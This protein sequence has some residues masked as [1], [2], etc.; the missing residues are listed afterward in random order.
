[1]KILNT[2]NIALGGALLLWVNISA[3][4]DVYKWVDKDGKIHYSDQPPL[5]GDAKKM[6]RKSKDTAA[7]PAAASPAGDSAKPAPSIADQELEYR[8]RKGEKEEVD[9]KQQAD[10][11]T[12]KKNKDYCSNLQGE[13]RSHTNGTRLIRYNDKGERVFLDE[14]ERAESKT[15]LETRIAKDC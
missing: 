1:M 5:A 8:K 10:A 15:Q 6:K 13:L 14:K 4:A 2:I 7:V 11:E 12:A 3:I 9:K